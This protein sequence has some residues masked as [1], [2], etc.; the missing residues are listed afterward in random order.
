MKRSAW[1]RPRD[2]DADGDETDESTTERS[3]VVGVVAASA[4]QVPTS[5]KLCSICNMKA[6]QFATTLSLTATTASAFVPSSSSCSK[7]K[8]HSAVSST[9]ASAST[10]GIQHDLTFTPPDTLGEGQI[11]EQLCADAAEK[12]KRVMVPVSKDVSETGY[13]GI[14]YIHWPAERK[15]ATLPL[16]LVPGFDSSALELRR[17]GPQLA[18]LGVE[19]YVVDLLGWGF[20][21]LD[22]IKS[23]SADSKV[24]ALKGFWQ[25]VGGNGEV[26]VGGCSLGGASVIT[27]AAENLYKADGEEENGFVRGT[28][29]ID[30]QGFIDGI[31]P[32]SFLPSPVARL[33]IKFLQSEGLRNQASQMSY[34]NPEAYATDDAMKI[35][36]LHCVRDG[37][38]D[39]M[40]S[41]MQ[42]GGFK[43]KERVA[44]ISV[45]SLILWGR[46]DGILEKEFASKFVETMEDAELQW[47]EECGHVPHLEQP[48]AVARYIMDFLS[49]DK[50]RPNEDEKAN[51]PANIL[52]GILNFLN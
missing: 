52:D 38:E 40:L 33:G 45:P 29:L 8:Q 27:L 44:Q 35:S 50:L 47:V 28:I 48:E 3:Q 2:D 20:T 21:Q 4:W 26:V 13:A 16:L 11:T 9:S 5:S 36:R 10:R 12:M 23:F 25:V 15:T 7:R 17:L 32:M 30:A 39:G 24:E 14:S 1:R 34:F 41:F 6:L 19:T 22:G 51:S 18:K 37:W 42:S 49:S 43:P 46:Q 31:G